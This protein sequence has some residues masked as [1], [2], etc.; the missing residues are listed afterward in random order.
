MDIEEECNGIHTLPGEDLSRLKREYT[1]VLKNC[2]DLA[3]TIYESRIERSMLKLRTKLEIVH[4][5]Q[6][7]I[8]RKKGF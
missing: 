2:D 7:E 6:G 3:L 4:R 1:E 8:R 5:L